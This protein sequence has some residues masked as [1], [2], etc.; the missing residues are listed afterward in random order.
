MNGPPQSVLAL[1]YAAVAGLGLL[2]LQNQDKEE[3]QEDLSAAFPSAEAPS[4]ELLAS[5]IAAS[6][7]WRADAAKEYDKRQL[8]E[9]KRKLEAEWFAAYNEKLRS[10]VALKSQV[11]RSASSQVARNRGVSAKA[12]T[13]AQDQDV[14][15]TAKKRGVW[16]MLRS[17]FGKK[18]K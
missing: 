14:A 8:A 16:A 3:P 18:Q 11:L 7:K 1:S 6:D 4:S 2:F 15:P 13:E 17:A 10:N 5:G 9:Q 12:S